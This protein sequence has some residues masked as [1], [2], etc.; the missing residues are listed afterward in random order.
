VIQWTG[1]L[2]EKCK[3]GVKERTEG[4][5]FS[6]I[7]RSLYGFDAGNNPS[8]FRSPPSVDNPVNKSAFL[9]EHAQMTWLFTKLPTF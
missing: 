2:S 4:S 5:E 6:V 3:K 9:L 8:H 1:G 7:P